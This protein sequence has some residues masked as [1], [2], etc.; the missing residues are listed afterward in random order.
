MLVGSI[1]AA[2]LC[3]SA[4][5]EIT[6]LGSQ[7]DPLLVVPGGAVN[8]DLGLGPGSNIAWHDLYYVILSICGMEQ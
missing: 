3:V 7:P 4:L 6:I 8:L 5:R 2:I 1:H